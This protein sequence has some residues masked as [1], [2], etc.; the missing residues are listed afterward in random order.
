MIARA[1][2][3]THAER[4]HHQRRSE[5]GY[6]GADIAGAE[7]AERGALPLLREPPG[8]IGD[9]DRER[10]A[11]DADAERRQQEGRVAVGEGEQRG[12]YRR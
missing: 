1:A 2:A 4:Y 11:R 5:L 9:A 12:H 6:R 8:D 7:D 3:Q 10:T